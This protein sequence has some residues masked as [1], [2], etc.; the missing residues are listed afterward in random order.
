MNC[1]K[2]GTPIKWYD[3]APNCKKCGVHIMY[4][5]QEK[6][7]ATDAKRT[8]L[9]FARARAF[10]ARL[11]AAF[12]SGAAPI[13]RMVFGV[14]CVAALAIPLGTITV[15]MPFFE[16]KITLGAIGI[17]KLISDGIL[18]IAADFATSGIGGSVSTLTIAG[19][20]CFVLCALCILALFFAWILSFTNLKKTAKAQCVIISLAV[21]FAAASEILI[22]AASKTAGDTGIV[23]VSPCIWG[24]LGIIAV[25]TAFLIPDAKIMRNPPEI[26]VSDVDKQR[27][28]IYAKVKAGELSLDDLPIP[29]LETD[30]ERLKRE[31]AM[32]GIPAKKKKS[33]KKGDDE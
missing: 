22:F 12:I 4:Y 13:A 20:A 5:T 2:C 30:E 3:L 18:G 27:I 26:K 8:E 21:V 23:S 1:P 29:I 10:V 11:K 33:K 16:S 25:F 9:E 31:N 32:A 6:S 24:V 17:Y 7:L 28:E 19:L 14:L 15:R